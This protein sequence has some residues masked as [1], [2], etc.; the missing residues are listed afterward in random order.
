MGMLP[1]DKAYHDAKRRARENGLPWL[2]VC[3]RPQADPPSYDLCPACGSPPD[4]LI[5]ILPSAGRT[6]EALDEACSEALQVA[7]LSAALA[8]LRDMFNDIG[9]N[10]EVSRGKLQTAIKEIAREISYTGSNLAAL[11]IERDKRNESD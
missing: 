11:Y 5:G 3:G 2:C 7:V 4:A 9:S 8:R 10:P 1:I 6:C